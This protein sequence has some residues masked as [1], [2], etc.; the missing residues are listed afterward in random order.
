MAAQGG[1]AGTPG[2][3]ALGTAGTSAGDVAGGAVTPDIA[4]DAANAGMLANQPAVQGLKTLYKINDMSNNINGL[5]QQ[6]D[7]SN[8]TRAEG[9]QLGQAIIAT[10]APN[11]KD[12]IK[13]QM[14]M[15][16]F[17]MGF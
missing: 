13:N 9:N 6:P 11:F 16:N 7:Y 1:V 4:G 10:P 14:L 3:E 17:G 15:N 12:K 5:T 2:T 8:I